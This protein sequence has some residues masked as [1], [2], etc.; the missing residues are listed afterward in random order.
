[1]G[2]SAQGVR[3]ILVPL[4]NGALGR[5]LP[6]VDP[7]EEVREIVLTSVIGDTLPTLALMIGNGTTPVYLR[8]VGSGIRFREP[9]STGITL[10]APLPPN[11]P[12]GTALM[13]T[14]L[15]FTVVTVDNLELIVSANT[16]PW[17]FAW[18]Y[19]V[20]D[21]IAAAAGQTPYI[22]LVRPGPANIQGNREVAARAY[23]AWVTSSITG[24]ASIALAFLAS[25]IDTFGVPRNQDVSLP[26][27]NPV[28]GL[29]KGT[30]GP[31]GGTSQDI[32]GLQAGVG[33]RVPFRNSAPL[34]SGGYEGI[35]VNGPVGATL[36]VSFDWDELPVDAVQP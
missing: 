36:T 5:P 1:M 15:E 25:R 6:V 12:A 35:C 24:L 23:G 33:Q 27:P 26:G 18:K 3:R 22:A 29:Q 28:L 4:S 30:D 19:G 9:E 13:R 20:G 14:W 32:V 11:T 16:D 2:S 17:Q 7:G 31:H 8:G 10:L 21:S 34:N